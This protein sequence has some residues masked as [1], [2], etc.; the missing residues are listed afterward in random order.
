MY[1]VKR[2][3]HLKITHHSS[4]S[5]QLPLGHLECHLHNGAGRQEG[6]GGGSLVE[7]AAGETRKGK[8]SGKAASASAHPSAR[9]YMD[10][11]VEDSSALARGVRAVRLNMLST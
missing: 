6:R 11:N 5:P 4:R 7:I 3:I 1:T 9:S 2:T 10:E 8:F